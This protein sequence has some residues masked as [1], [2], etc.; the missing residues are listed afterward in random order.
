MTEQ[1][2]GLFEL[3]KAPNKRDDA[4]DLFRAGNEFPVGEDGDSFNELSAALNS[5]YYSGESSGIALHSIVA[6]ADGSF[7][8]SVEVPK[9]DNICT[10]LRCPDGMI[11]EDGFCVSDEAL[12]SSEGC[13]CQGQKADFGLWSLIFVLVFFWRKSAYRRFFFL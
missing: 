1:A 5:N 4:G 8:F 7:S 13:G 12:D 2:D 11:C 10:D 3:Q 9:L 6:E